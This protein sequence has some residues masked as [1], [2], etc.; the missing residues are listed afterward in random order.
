MMSAPDAVPRQPCTWFFETG[1]LI[2]IWQNSLVKLSLMTSEPQGQL[3]CTSSA[4]KLQT[5]A[6][7]S[8]LCKNARAK[9]RFSCL[10][11]EHCTN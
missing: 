8:S 4:L 11:I 9:L 3:V 6:T 5:C 7:T 10:Q 2:R 1:S